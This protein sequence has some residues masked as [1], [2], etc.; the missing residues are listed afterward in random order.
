[1]AA[2]AKTRKKKVYSI[3]L[4]PGLG[5]LIS[6]VYFTIQQIGAPVER[7]YLRLALAFV[8]FPLSGLILG[9]M[10]WTSYENRYHL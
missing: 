5:V 3:I 1:M 9:H 7:W 2:I 8:M 10:A 4:G 6:L